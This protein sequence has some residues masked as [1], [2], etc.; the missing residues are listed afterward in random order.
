[1]LASPKCGGRANPFWD[2]GSMIPGGDKLLDGSTETVGWAR[3]LLDLMC[4]I[5]GQAATSAWFD[6]H[7][8]N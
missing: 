5:L 8:F 6:L 1:M 7:F 4:W 3:L 2:W